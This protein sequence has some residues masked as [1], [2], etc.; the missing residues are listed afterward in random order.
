MVYTTARRYNW[1]TE[2]MVAHGI[3]EA[4]LMMNLRNI[5]NNWQ[6]EAAYQTAAVLTEYPDAPKVL[7][8]AAE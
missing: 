2:W 5:V 3:T 6:G 8:P 4:D 1:V 7:G